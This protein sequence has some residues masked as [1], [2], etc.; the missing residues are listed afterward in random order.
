MSFY[1]K[2]R[3]KKL[4]G[5]WYPASVTSGVLTTDELISELAEISTVSK[6]DV[7]AV[8]GNLATVMG[9]NMAKG[10]TVKINDLGTFYLS[11]VCSG[12][13]VD[14]PEEVSS[15]QIKGVKVHF[16]PETTFRNGQTVRALTSFDIDWEE[17]TEYTAATSES[18]DTED[19]E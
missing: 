10:Y 4:S 8:L 1:Y 17:M 16:I 19:E 5:K 15:K 11:A 13:G 2:R 7:N 3:Y 9:R 18:S 12:N 6:S 14:T